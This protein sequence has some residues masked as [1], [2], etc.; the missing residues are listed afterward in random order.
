MEALKADKGVVASVIAA[1]IGFTLFCL[2]GVAVLLGWIGPGVRPGSAPVNDLGLSPGET[3]VT[4]ETRPAAKAAA[5]LPAP[6]PAPAPAAAAPVA[7]PTPVPTPPP[8]HENRR[9]RKSHHASAPRAVPE[10]GA[11]REPDR[12][13]PVERR[14]PIPPPAASEPQS[15]TIAA[16]THP[17]DPTDHWPQPNCGNCGVVHSITTY[18]DLWE[19]RVRF[20]DGG[21]RT[22]RYHRSPRWRVGDRIRYEG[23]RLERE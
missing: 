14:K 15:P 2:V 17:T 1:A 13:E 19:V 22:I 6:A 11:R 23:G 21:R 9:P 4:A 20:D 7:V 18:P 8:A 12:R 16:A 10:A 3:L 5:P